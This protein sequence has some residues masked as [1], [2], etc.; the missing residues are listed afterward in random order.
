MTLEVIGSGFGR[1]GTASLRLALE[2]LGFVRCHHMFEVLQNPEQ[3]KHWVKAVRGEP[4]DWDAVFE[5]YRA[6]V[7]WPSAHF[8][9]ELAEYYPDAKVL[10]SVRDPAAWYESVKNT[11]YQAITSGAAPADVPAAISEF[12]GAVREMIVE[13]TFGG[14]FEDRERMLAMF[15]EHTETVK[16][17]IPPERLLVYDVAEGWE[18]LC[19]FLG[20]PVPDEPFPRTNT[21]DEFRGRMGLGPVEG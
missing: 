19:R 3:M 18:P 8:W 11:I 7:D 12:R 16:A 20:C 15:D 17:T 14:S 9:R 4:V 21:T 10:H 5:G 2:K 1:T 13:R 6:A